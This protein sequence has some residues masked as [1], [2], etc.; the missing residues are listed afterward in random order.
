MGL[1]LSMNWRQELSR[2]A[3]A[4]R[5]PAAMLDQ[6]WP[7]Q[8]G[9]PAPDAMVEPLTRFAGSA[10]RLAAVLPD[11]PAPYTMPRSA[12]NEWAVD[13]RHTATGC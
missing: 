1:W 13:G 4:G 7:R 10:S 9:V 3:L 5:V 2:Q 11:F 8:P 6:L 12:S